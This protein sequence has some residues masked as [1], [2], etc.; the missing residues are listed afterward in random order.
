MPAPAT[1][2][3]LPALLLALWFCGFAVVLVYGWTR[4]RRVAAAVRK[5]L[6]A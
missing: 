2:N 3:L 1:G 4:W 6:A 5:Y